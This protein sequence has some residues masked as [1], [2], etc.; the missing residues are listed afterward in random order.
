MKKAVP[1]GGRKAE[2]NAG[3]K[4]V[5]NERRGEGDFH[6]RKDNLYMVWCIWGEMIN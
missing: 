4:D 5:C 2:W 6:I 1:Q 3:K